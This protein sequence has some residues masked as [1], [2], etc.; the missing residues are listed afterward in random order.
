[1][2]YM[3]NTRDAGES[4]FLKEITHRRDTSGRKRK[5]APRFPDSQIKF[6]RVMSSFSVYES[7]CQHRLPSSC[8]S[9]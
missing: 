2:F 6:T 1:M 7:Q 8:C 4:T 3:D 5:V 9:H